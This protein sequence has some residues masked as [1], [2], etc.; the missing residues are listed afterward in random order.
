M[1]RTAATHLKTMTAA[2]ETEKDLSPTPETETTDRIGHETNLETDP[3][4]DLK[5]DLETTLLATEV[6]RIGQT[7]EPETGQRTGPKGTGPET[8]IRDS[9]VTLTGDKKADL[10]EETEVEINL[11]LL[12][13]A[14]PKGHP[15]E[16]DTETETVLHLRDD[17]ILK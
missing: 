1:S 4:T 6:F 3:Q 16:T 8:E 12:H 13:E 17:P 5:I 7:I 14:D 15:P 10:L 2:G 9:L 11:P